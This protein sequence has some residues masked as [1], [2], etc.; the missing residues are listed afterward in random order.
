MQSLAVYIGEMY[1]CCITFVAN[2]DS[3]ELLLGYLSSSCIWC[4]WQDVLNW[5]IITEEPRDD[6]QELIVALVTYSKQ[7][8]RLEN[9]NFF[10]WP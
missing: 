8:Y 7:A 2:P 6:T 1:R 3:L 4:S 9:L 5:R 10:F